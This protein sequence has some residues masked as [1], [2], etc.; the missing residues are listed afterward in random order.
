MWAASVTS[1][2][3]N[4]SRRQSIKFVFTRSAFNVSDSL[5]LLVVCIRLAALEVFLI[6]EDNWNFRS[7]QMVRGTF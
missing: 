6:A 7:H 4:V 1:T 2:R 5:C 3:H